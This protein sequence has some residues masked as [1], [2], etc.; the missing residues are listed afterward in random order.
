MLEKFVE[1]V[2]EIAAGKT[3]QEKLFKAV[4][5]SKPRKLYWKMF[6]KWFPRFHG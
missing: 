1:K 3:L 6:L 4:M 2:L 5:V